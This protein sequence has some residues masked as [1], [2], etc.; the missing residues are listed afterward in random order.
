M[1]LSIAQRFALIFA[2]VVFVATATVGF[3]V[4]QGS[5]RALIK[6]ATERLGHTSERV[7]QRLA[8]DIE[9]IANDLRF[10]TGTPAVEGIVRTWAAREQGYGLDRETGMTVNDWRDQLADLFRVF[11]ENHTT[12]LQIGFSSVSSNG[13][14]MLRLERREDAIRRIPQEELDEIGDQQDFQQT[15][16]L[17]QGTLYLSPITLESSW[18]SDLSEGRPSLRAALPVYG[19]N[20]R[21]Y[22]FLQIQIDMEKVFAGLRE[23]ADDDKWLYLANKDGYFLIHPDPTRTFGF[24]RGQ[25][26]L[27]QDTFADAAA[28]IRGEDTFLP[29]D[30]ARSNTGE[31]VSA[32]F[33]RIDLGEGV[34]HRPLILG[35]TAPHATILADVEQVRNRSLLITLLFSLC[36]IVFALAFSTWLTRPLSRIT[37]ALSRFKRGE[38][39]EALP[40]DRQ[41]EIGLMARTLRDMADEIQRQVIELES[42]ELRQRTILETSAE[43]IIVTGAEGAIETFNAAAE[44]IL[45]YP[46]EDVIGQPI[47]AY[48]QQASGKAGTIADM[49]WLSINQRGEAVGLHKE[50]HPVPLLVTWSTFDLHGEQRVTILL[51]D[52]TERKSA[53]VL[54]EKLLEELRTE[55]TRLQQL[56]ESLEERVEARTADLD[57]TNKVLEYRNREL[58]D[59]AYVASHDLQEPLRKIQAFSGLLISEFGEQIDEDGQF[60]VDRMKD[61]AARMSRLISDLLAFSRITTRARPYE[62]VDLNEII[63]G[64]LYDL[65]IRLE[66]TGGT[67]NVD[68]LPAIEADPLQMQQLFQNLISNGLKFHRDGV[69]PVIHVRGCIEKRGLLVGIDGEV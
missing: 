22:G 1:N 38:W 36:G 39:G 26:Y 56:S 68:P 45:G 5:R 8:S 58:Q 69:P 32:F 42:K 23:V 12:Y 47:D 50:G 4:Y 25:Q 30:E 19:A 51:H 33:S 61:A 3:T 17:E 65:E 20:G 67:V 34:S 40:V 7:E 35:I 52:I 57:R 10:L 41:D 63:E 9:S 46:S 44:H 48:I 29:I 64:V 21:V 55:R 16:Q 13:Q 53:E 62:E 31:P 24:E 60:Y 2:L 43:G 18:E 66:E 37:R 49:P 54:R 15:I 11:L 28:I 59:F 14:E 27:I 6:A